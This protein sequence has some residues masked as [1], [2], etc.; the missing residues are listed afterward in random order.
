MSAEASTLYCSVDSCGWQRGMAPTWNQQPL[1][2]ALSTGSSIFQQTSPWFRHAGASW[3]TS[4][5][6]AY[7][8]GKRKHPQH[9]CTTSGLM[10]V[11]SMLNHVPL[12]Y[13]S[14]VLLRGIIPRF[15]LWWTA[16]SRL[17]SSRFT[18]FTTICSYCTNYA[19]IVAVFSL[20]LRW[21]EFWLERQ[22]AY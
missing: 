11:Q 20:P 8:K 3:S 12:S 21:N 7:A 14:R 5:I 9:I 4:K 17:A 10:P 13:I 16:P 1:S 18:G 6:Q 19:F 15:V 22:R 2:H